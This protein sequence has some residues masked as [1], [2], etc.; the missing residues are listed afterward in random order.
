MSGLEGAATSAAAIEVMPRACPT[1][2]FRAVM[3][4]EQAEQVPNP[5]V[6][7]PRSSIPLRKGRALIPIA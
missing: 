3:S 5:L 1:A 2:S 4:R 7:G 6:A